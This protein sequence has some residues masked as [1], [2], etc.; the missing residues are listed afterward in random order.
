MKTLRVTDQ[1][2]FRSWMHDVMSV[3]GNQPMLLKG[4]CTQIANSCTSLLVCL[5][6]CLFAYLLV[7]LIVCLLAY[8]SVCLLCC[9]FICLYCPRQRIQA[10][11]SQ[12][13]QMCCRS[14]PCSS[15]SGDAT[16]RPSCGGKQAFRRLGDPARVA[17]MMFSKG[18]RC[19]CCICSSR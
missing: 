4:G 14:R 15:H 9:L 16:S 8:L 7:C 6:A 3:G 17:L 2:A 19:C 1:G 5:C 12:S 18:S 10:R 11:R 13:R